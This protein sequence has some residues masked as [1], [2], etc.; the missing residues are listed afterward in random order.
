MRT[1]R[2]DVGEVLASAA[3]NSPASEI[4]LDPP[5]A[6]AGPAIVRQIAARRPAGVV[7]VSCDP[8]TLGRDLAVFAAQGYE[9]ERMA[10]F[11]MFPDTF[12]LE[13][14]VRLTPRR[15]L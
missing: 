1:L 15:N 5:R 14:V 7:Y 4:V 13:T 9:P 6:G 10:A 11:D 8:T 3:A 2:G 12:H